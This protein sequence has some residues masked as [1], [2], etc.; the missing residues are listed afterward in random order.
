VENAFFV[1]LGNCDS[2]CGGGGVVYLTTLFTTN[3]IHTLGDWLMQ[4]YGALME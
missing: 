3:I 4:V 1:F 2:N